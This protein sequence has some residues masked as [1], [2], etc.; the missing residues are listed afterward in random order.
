MD[1]A[2]I[3]GNAAHSDHLIVH[4]SGVHGPDAFAGSAIQCAILHKLARN[5]ND[6]QAR[7]LI[8]RNLRLYDNDNNGSKQWVNANVSSEEATTTTDMSAFPVIMLV[9]AFNPYGMYYGVVGNEN[10]VDLNLHAPSSPSPASFDA[11]TTTDTC[12]TDQASTVVPTDPDAI[13][14]F[15][16]PHYGIQTM[17]EFT[18][19][20]I[21]FAQFF[22]LDWVMHYAWTFAVD[23]YAR[24]QCAAYYFF[25]FALP[26]SNDDDDDQESVNDAVFERYAMAQSTD[27]SALLQVSHIKFREF[28]KA[29]FEEHNWYSQFSKITVVDVHTGSGTYGEDTTAVFDAQQLEYAQHIG[30][31]RHSHIARSAQFNSAKFLRGMYANVRTLSVYET[32]RFISQ[33]LMR[34]ADKVESFAV[35]EHFG[36]FSR[37]YVLNAMRF[38]H[39]YRTE[40][41]QY[42]EEMD[43]NDARQK[44]AAVLLQF[45]NG[46]AN[47]IL[48]DAFDV[49]NVEWKR[50]VI[51]RG[52]NT[53]ADLYGR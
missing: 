11:T 27:A 30:R 32:M 3:N 44:D 50:Q 33:E 13:H 10:N 14:S 8:T 31:A 9:H 39:A 21:P 52:V 4:I 12:G 53:F 23:W 15:L 28:L 45:M 37:Q 26:S 18:T 5:H 46:Y 19:T 2:V 7:K 38:A 16:H 24:T 35:Y 47:G 42:L 48:K 41:L 43:I 20:Y 51:R 1:V 29:R 25:H 22:K 6:P 49:P 36:T 40:Y 34:N 17:V